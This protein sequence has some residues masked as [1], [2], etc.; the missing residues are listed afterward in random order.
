MGWTTLAKPNEI[1]HEFP[2]EFPNGFPYHVSNK[3]PYPNL[4]DCGGCMANVING[5]GKDVGSSK[6]CTA[7]YG[8]LTKSFDGDT[9]KSQKQFQSWEN[10]KSSRR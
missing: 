2:N 9:E 7:C 5:G 8:H 6:E 10:T 4:V 3:F 1:H